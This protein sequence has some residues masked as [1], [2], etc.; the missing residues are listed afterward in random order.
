MKKDIR[1]AIADRILIV[2]GAMGTQIQAFN[3]SEDDFRGNRFANHPYK[4]AGCNDVLCLTRPDVILSIHRNYIAAGADIIETNSFNS[5]AISLAD[6][7][8]EDLV[9]D[10]NREAAKLARRAAD[11]ADCVWVAGSVGPTN[12]TLSMSA[13]VD[14]PAAR[15]TSFDELL[16]TYCDQMRG[17]IDGGVDIIQIETI[18]DTLN[19]KAAVAA[20]ES[21]MEISG[22]RVEL[23][24]SATPA[25]GGRTLS[26][27]TIEALI[28]S[29]AHANPLAFGL[30]CGFGAD[31]MAPL[32][33]EFAAKSAF[34]TIVYP[35]AGLP[36]AL[37]EYDETPQ[38]MAAH[39]E[40]I[41]ADGSAN[42]IGGCC[43][44]TP[45]HIHALAELAKR[46]NP[47]Q[48]PE[49]PQKLTLAGLDAIDITAERNFVNIGERC[50]VAGSR[51]FLRLIN[52]K[53][54]DE[55]CDI[56]RR[57]VENG[58]QIIDI[59]MDDAMLDAEAEMRRFVNLLSSDPDIARVPFMLD[60]SKWNVIQAGL[61]C[62]QGKGIVNSIS[63][64]EGEATFVDHAR[65]VKSM[66]AA[67]VV[68]AFDE[69]GQAD[70]FDRRIAIC[71]R[72]YRILVDSVGFNPNDIIFDPNIL[73]VATGIEG[74]NRY[75]L[76]FIE[77][78]RW[79]KQNLPGA[80]VSG[81]V[82]NL[83]FSFRGN[84]YIREAMH[85]V[86]LYHAIRAGL[87]MAI[88]NAAALMP[89]SEVPDDLKTAIEDVIFDRRLDATDRLI[90][91]ADSL[92]NTDRQADTVKTE[93][94][95]SL[96]PDQRIAEMLVKGR[97]DN[98]EALLSEALALHGS[99]IAVIERSL[100]AG[101]NEVGRL[102]GEGKMFLPQVVKSA[103]MMKDAVAWLQPLIEAE[104][105]GNSGRNA[106]KILMATVKG[107]VHDIGKNIV[108]VVLRCNGFEVVDLGI[109][110]PAEQ[111]LDKA[112]EI[113]ADIIGLSGLITP[114]LDE[115]CNV[116]RLAQQRGMSTPILVGGATASP[117]HT[118]VKI[119]PCYDGLVAYIRDAAMMP[120]VARRI[121][122]NRDATAAEIR[123]DQL[124]LRS[125]YNAEAP[126]SL[127]E[128]RRMRHR[129]S[130]GAAPKPNRPGVTKIDIKV[131]DVV[132]FI[133]WRAFFPVWNLDASFAELAEIR[134][135]GHC[136]A[137]WIAAQKPERMN[138][139]MEAQ[140]LLKDAR[141]ALAR[142]IREADDSMKAVV[143]IR[144]AHSLGDDII[145]DVDGS[146]LVIPTLRRQHRN[147]DGCCLALADF[148]ASADDFL[149]AFAV[150]SGS[151][152]QAIIDGYK[153]RD[154]YKLLLYQ[155]LADRL[156]E[157][158]AEFV[159]LQVRR[160]IWGYAPDESADPRPA[161]SGNYIGIRPA[162]GYPSLPDQA[163]VFAID[164]MLGG[165]DA[166]EISLTE[167]G[168]MMPA[169][170]VA[171]LFIA[172]PEARYF[173]VGDIDDD[174]RAD[175]ADRRGISLDELAKWLPR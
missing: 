124:R 36:N 134:G 13:S 111:I 9:Y 19:A 38:M 80:K 53:N 50:N 30:N 65:F 101:M 88:V 42:I 27:Q 7:G 128:A 77:A 159:H 119:A 49:I 25:V 175:Y 93:A 167:N 102:F 81:G 150:T 155:S 148:V 43:G 156:A 91:L 54:Y 114:S 60:S 131:S 89:Y 100:M 52:E 168:A 118:A 149:G 12:K 76:D 145:V 72:A 73:A 98:L 32:I 135:C 108:D 129:C 160:S 171:G 20:A 22:R 120:A 35:N 106:G 47:R 66:G 16:A 163:S 141:A 33:A 58:A 142:L 173:M 152:I 103:R 172:N 94:A 46:Y 97:C 143:A 57:Q 115:M 113:G 5:N 157:A 99:A 147:A 158:A 161:L 18:F 154:D 2:D 62:L 84:N 174:Q 1:N 45:D 122:D 164:K 166:A 75:A 24:I 137:Q 105:A 26:G 153:G 95:Q 87:D 69:Q 67:V 165:I 127:D 139:I 29:L 109:M 92:K 59:N 70:T 133:N 117:L 110:V 6:Y 104:Q 63:L 82:S 85:A 78:T 51:K 116:A 90:E 146:P 37:G 64:K 130:C 74:H 144:S 61:K 151:R 56:A 96:S 136:Q 123:A 44:T 170:S 169:S 41:L 125:Q 17:L 40:R 11:E 8:L 14:D 79:I 107:D 3:L 83:S 71:S 15:E 86:F 126:L 34:P 10:L 140:N 48:L 4:L 55:A 132:D 39:V 121:I 23:I 31:T 68:M 162:A 112:A 138:K 28:A 21:A